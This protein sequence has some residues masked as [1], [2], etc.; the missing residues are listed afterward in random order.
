MPRRSC[1][2]RTRPLPLDQRVDDLL[3]RLTLDEKISLLH[4]YAAGDPAAG[5]HV[6][7]AGTEALHGVAWSNDRQ[8]RRGRDRERHRVPAGRRPGQHLGPG[9][10]QAGRLGRRR[11]GARLQRDR[12]RRVG[13][14]PVGAGGQPAARPA[15]GPQRGGLLR[16]PAADRRDLHRVRHGPG[17]RRP[18][19]P[20]DR[21]RRSSTTWPTTT[22]SSRDV[23]SSNLRAAGAARVRRAGVQAGDLRGRGDRRHGLLQPGQRTADHGR[24]RPRTTVVRS[25]T[26]KDAVQRQ[27]RLRAVQPHRHRARTTPP[28]PR[29]TRR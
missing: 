4:Q 27:R 24:P 20:Q 28:S 6:F 22:R 3:G 11:R 23:T 21:A 9:A 17:G 10:D 19:L 15:L 7:K 29:P 26:D 12:T 1:R 8:R 13:P 18:A 2:T 25:W 14:Q 5:H 16:G